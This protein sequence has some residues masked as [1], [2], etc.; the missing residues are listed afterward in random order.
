MSNTLGFTTMA[1]G[2]K[3][4]KSG[5]KAKIKNA[6][7]TGNPAT[8]DKTSTDE[9]VEFKDEDSIH[10]SSGHH[11]FNISAMADIKAV[12]GN[13]IDQVTFATSDAPSGVDSNNKETPISIPFQQ[14]NSRRESEP[15]VT[16]SQHVRTK[17][18]INSRNKNP[19]TISENALERDGIKRLFQLATASMATSSKAPT[20]NDFLALLQSKGI[21]LSDPRLKA[22]R[23]IIEKESDKG[24]TELD[25]E[26]FGR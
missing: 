18:F 13:L 1:G 8:H 3:K 9:R 21:W 6:K 25:E 15:V 24:D 26:V 17:L 5:G 23:Q 12:V 16:L 4:S 10:Q 14:Y 20:V 22:T 7:K 11:K 2:N 19:D